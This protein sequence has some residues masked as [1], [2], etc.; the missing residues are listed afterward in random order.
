VDRTIAQVDIAVTRAAGDSSLQEYIHL[1]LQRVKISSVTIGASENATPNAPTEVLKLSPSSV[2][3]LYYPQQ[4]DGS[5]G[6]PIEASIN[7]T[8]GTA[9]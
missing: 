8:N 4:P 7:C 3:L 1:T 9:Q 6:S 5:L 2:T